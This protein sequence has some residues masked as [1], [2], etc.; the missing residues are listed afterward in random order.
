MV[1]RHG[2]Y[3]KAIT[4]S[5]TLAPTQLREAE[6]IFVSPCQILKCPDL[7]SAAAVGHL[8]PLHHALLTPPLPNKPDSLDEDQ[9]N[10]PE[11]FWVTDIYCTIHSHNQPLLLYMSSNTDPW[12]SE[13]PRLYKSEA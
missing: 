2:Y 8:E 10:Y 13:W 9:H 6:Q 12:Y 7:D 11:I 5:K 3:L 4:S 1:R